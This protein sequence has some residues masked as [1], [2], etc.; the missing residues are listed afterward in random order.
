MDTQILWGL[1]AAVAAVGL[2]IAE[3]YFPLPRILG[4]KEPHRTAAYVLGCLALLLPFTVW[5]LALGHV[6][7][8]L[9]IWTI[10]V[11]G[12]L[13]VLGCY[14]LD[15]L[16]DKRDLEKSNKRLHDALHGGPADRAD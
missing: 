15:G 5:G 4:G 10:T 3:H 1:V 9:V 12:G 14:A 16:L 13:A 7:P 6:V 2:L 8:V 11:L